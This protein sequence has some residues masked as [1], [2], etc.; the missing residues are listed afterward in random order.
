MVSTS[1]IR[2]DRLV[3]DMNESGSGDAMTRLLHSAHGLLCYLS[4]LGRTCTSCNV[5]EKTSVTG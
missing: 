5:R 3:T 2:S 4:L 1:T